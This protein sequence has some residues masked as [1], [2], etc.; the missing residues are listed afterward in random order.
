[1][2]LARQA[3]PRALTEKQYPFI[4]TGPVS[5]LSFTSTPFL[6]V[7]TSEEELRA[8]N[9]RSRLSLPPFAGQEWFN[10]AAETVSV[11]RNDKPRID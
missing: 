5:P 6:D 3:D 7:F 2:T 10:A 4:L 11:G 1:M 9:R 8:A